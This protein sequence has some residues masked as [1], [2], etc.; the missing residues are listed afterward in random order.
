MALRTRFCLLLYYSSSPTHIGTSPYKLII[1]LQHTLSTLVFITCPISRYHTMAIAHRRF[2]AHH[3]DTRAGRGA[4]GYFNGARGHFSGA[5]GRNNANP[6]ESVR[7]FHH[8]SSIRT[9][10]PPL[11]VDSCSHRRSSDEVF[12]GHGHGSRR[13]VHP[14]VPSSAPSNDPSSPFAQV[15]F[16][17][18]NHAH[19]S[20]RA[21]PLHRAT[22]QS[23]RQSSQPT[24]PYHGSSTAYAYPAPATRTNV[25]VDSNQTRSSRSMRRRRRKSCRRNSSSD[26]MTFNLQRF[27]VHV[28]TIIAQLSHSIPLSD[29]SCS[30]SILTEAEERYVLSLV[31]N[32]IKSRDIEDD[33]CNRQNIATHYANA[34]RS[35]QHLFSMLLPLKVIPTLQQVTPTLLRL[36]PPV[37]PLRTLTIYLKSSSLL[38]PTIER[39]LLHQLHR[40]KIPVGMKALVS[41]PLVPYRS[42]LQQTLR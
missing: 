15:H 33:I 26:P 42:L 13:D 9:D 3:G 25:P 5:R 34:I 28:D 21:T 6:H 32:I 29:D 27:T 4:R 40:L 20:G 39:L 2:Q 31:N 16:D 19:P 38:L 41:T 18:R 36:L 14:Q 30:T 23:R 37:R 35:Q 7:A 24:M 22:S 12:F 17:V 8:G 10:Q 1:C 11:D